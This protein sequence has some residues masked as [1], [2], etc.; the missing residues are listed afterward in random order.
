MTINCKTIDR[1]KS[2]EYDDAKKQHASKLN[3]KYDIFSPAKIFYPR[4][5]DDIIEIVKYANE[6]NI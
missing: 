2:K 6:K 3:A 5:D 4:G 1:N